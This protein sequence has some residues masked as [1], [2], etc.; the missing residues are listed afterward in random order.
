MENNI[1]NTEKT[2]KKSF[3]E[4]KN[5]SYKIFKKKKYFRDL[6]S[7]LTVLFTKN[8]VPQVKDWYNC[9]EEK[10]IYLLWFENGEFGIRCGKKVFIKRKGRRKKGQKEKEWD[11]YYFYV[12]DF[13]L[14]K[15]WDITTKRY[16]E[17]FIHSKKINYLKTRKG[18]HIYVLSKEPI[19]NRS[20][21]FGSGLNCGSFRGKGQQIN[22]STEKEIV[23]KKGYKK[24]LKVKDQ[25][26]LEKILAK[27]YFFIKSANLI[28]KTKDKKERDK[29]IK[30][31]KKQGEIFFKE[32]NKKIISLKI[33]SVDEVFKNWRMGKPYKLKI[34][35]LTNNKIED[36]YLDAY[37]PNQKK[38][39][40]LVDQ[41]IEVEINQGVYFNFFNRVIF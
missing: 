6:T 32:I 34:K 28:A 17:S 16:I 7:P 21:R 5:T 40:S 19:E 20:L 39:L 13:D 22:F 15:G 1:K 29:L 12:L 25:K 3:Q 37:Y 14:P 24:F 35:N 27:F 8:K 11:E 33:V 41:E 31:F 30:A 18:F 4:V 38:L 36:I 9:I 26:D 23:V 2:W 10:S